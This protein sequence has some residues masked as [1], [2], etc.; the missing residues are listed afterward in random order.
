V[1]D[2]INSDRIM[3]KSPGLEYRAEIDGLRA[4]AVLAV[5]AHHV[6]QRLLP[7]GYVGVDVFFVIS[8]FLITSILSR[9]L[10]AGNF[11]FAH[12]YARRVKRLVPA[13]TVMVA[14]VLGV[15]A[16]F[17]LPFDFRNL[18]ASA[19]A[20]AG[21]VSNVLFWKWDD[22]FA[23]QNK[24]WPL[25]HTW[26]LAVEE[27]FYLV[28]PLLLWAIA[29]RPRLITAVL[30][31]LAAASLA[32]SIY[33]T[34]IYPRA[35]YY[36]L[37]ARAWELAAGALC[38]KAP[39]LRLRSASNSALCT[40]AAL[41]IIGPMATFTHRTPF[42]GWMAGLPVI[43][44]AALIWV[45]SNADGLLRRMLRWPALVWVG[46]ISYSLY[47]WHWPL[48][49]L[50]RYPW[51]AAPA[52]QPAI[53]P[54]LAGAISLPIAW[55]SYR[56]VEKPTR[57]APVSDR[58]AIL[59]AVGCGLVVAAI[60]SMAHRSNGLPGRLPRQ[61]VA[62][63]AAAADVNPRRDELMLP[64]S[65]VRQGG[66][67]RLGKC[68]FQSSPV[69]ALWGDSFADAIAPGLDDL[70]RRRGVAGIGFARH[71]TPP[72]SGV[73]I[74]LH[75]KYPTDHDFTLAVLDQLTSQPV[76]SVVLAANWQLY[77]TSADLVEDGRV[78]GSRTERIAFLRR[79]L[80][81]TIAALRQAGTR[82]IWIVGEPPSQPFH[83]PKQLALK[84]AWA[85]YISQAPL[86]ATVRPVFEQGR[87]DLDAMLRGF[88][89]SSV[90]FID[91]AAAMFTRDT[92]L[93]TDDGRPMYYDQ[94][95]LSASGALAIKGV[96]E[97]VFADVTK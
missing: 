70:A 34:A 13:G 49:M 90:G 84:A 5:L 31:C 54:Y 66:G 44:T 93:L 17:F 57:A 41:L 53:V 30:V 78:A 69:F 83:V 43:G 35:A 50:A 21:M 89:S 36:L 82:H 64:T 68:D 47:L 24:I 33:Q 2:A 26:S 74:Q 37:P 60:G 94:A 95:H 75:D 67:A 20:Y 42:P 27:Q 52:D 45:T 1:S 73:T 86:E 80:E 81:R 7:G 4:I 62:Y 18:G 48:I 61:A 9:D 39:V 19:V 28:Y 92:Q 51:A 79:G 63:D 8:G 38:S 77:V 10:E 25:L 22:Y 97:P 14:V 16:L 59:C 56:Y 40:V 12:F 96:F 15:S 58:V 32:I 6:D 71:S 87:P 85:R 91:I 29:R 55:I 88:S 76:A 23:S 3:Q 72:V 65:M 11:S 46:Q